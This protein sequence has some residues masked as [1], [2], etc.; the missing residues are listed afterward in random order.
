MIIQIDCDTYLRQFALG[1][2]FSLSRNALVLLDFENENVFNI[3][4]PFSSD[5]TFGKLIIQIWPLL[6]LKKSQRNAKRL[7]SVVLKKAGERLTFSRTPFYWALLFKAI[8]CFSAISFII[9][10]DTFYCVATSYLR[11]HIQEITRE[12]HFHFKNGH[13]LVHFKMTFQK[14]SKYPSILRLLPREHEFNWINYRARGLSTVFDRP[15]FF[16]YVVK[17]L[18]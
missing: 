9:I 6:S 15:E 18:L 3:I 13:L 5:E 14:K 12:M 2:F 11:L 16:G 7:A 8:W 17:I 1:H 10:Q 4:F